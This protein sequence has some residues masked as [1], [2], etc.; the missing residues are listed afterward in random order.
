MKTI[1]LAVTVPDTYDVAAIRERE[2]QAARE[3]GT[4]DSQYHVARDLLDSPDMSLAMYETADEISN[5]ADRIKRADYYDDVRQVATE[6]ESEV[7]SGNITDREEALQWL[8]ETIDGHH[9]VIYTS[10]A[11]DVVRYSDN[12]GAYV[13]DFG[14]DGVV[15]DGDI[16]WSVLAYAA[17]ERDVIEALS[18]IDINAED[19]GQPKCEDCDEPLPWGTDDALCNDCA[20]IANSDDADE[21]GPSTPATEANDN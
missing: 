12:D 19:L 2:R 13:E 4:Y 8:H 7:M 1:Y 11:Q 16:D 14:V 10:C 3:R 9:D 17:M 5:E 6:L 20:D 15:R 18:A 21:D